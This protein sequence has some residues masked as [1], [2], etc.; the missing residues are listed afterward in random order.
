M[1]T[2]LILSMVALLYALLLDTHNIQEALIVVLGSI[3][4]YVVQQIVNMISIIEYPPVDC[5]A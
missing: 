2:V 4:D 1:A 3:F 5:G